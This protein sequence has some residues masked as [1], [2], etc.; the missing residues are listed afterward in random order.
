M[1]AKKTVKN[2]VKTKHFF[3]L[4]QNKS[5]EYRLPE[6]CRIKSLFFETETYRVIMDQ[7]YLLVL[8]AEL[9]YIAQL[10]Q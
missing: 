4:N 6:D 1:S 3:I 7:I 8:F 2:S 10:G 9:D 5:V